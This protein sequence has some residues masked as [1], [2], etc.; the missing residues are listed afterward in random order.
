MNNASTIA[1]VEH[2]RLFGEGIDLF[3]NYYSVLGIRNI[4]KVIGVR[5]SNDSDWFRA[6]AEFVTTGELSELYDKILSPENR[7]NI[8]SS[9]NRRTPPEV[10]DDDPTTSSPT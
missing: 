10:N 1:K 7:S 8:A 3:K 4:L 9:R 5:T 2:E 6:V